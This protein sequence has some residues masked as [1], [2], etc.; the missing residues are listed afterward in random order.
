MNEIELHFSE[1]DFKMFRKFCQENGIIKTKHL[2]KTVMKKVSSYRGIGEQK[3][4]RIEVR[5]QLLR[6][7]NILSHDWIDEFLNLKSPLATNCT[8]LSGE[9]RSIITEFYSV[10]H[11]ISSKLGSSTSFKGESYLKYMNDKKFSI[12]IGTLPKE[13]LNLRISTLLSQKHNSTFQKSFGNIKV[14]DLFTHH[15]S[16]DFKNLN[17]SL[18]IIEDIEKIL[19]SILSLEE[20]AGTIFKGL[21]ENQVLFLELRFLKKYTLEKCGK[22]FGFSRERARQIETSILKKIF[23]KNE[24]KE[25]VFGLRARN[26][27]LKSISKERAQL[28]LKNNLLVEILKSCEKYRIVYNEKLDSF[29]FEDFQKVIEIER[30]LSSLPDIFKVENYLWEISDLFASIDIRDWDDT[31]FEK[32]LSHFNYVRYGEFFSKKKKIDSLFIETYFEQVASQPFRVDKKTFVNFQYEIEKYFG[33]VLNGNLKSLYGCLDRCPEIIKTA[34]LTYFHIGKLN[35]DYNILNNAKNKLKALNRSYIPLDEAFSTNKGELIK[36]KIETPY[37]FYYLLKYE[38]KNELKLG[39]G[40]S[41]NLYFDHDIASKTREDIVYEAL[42][43]LGKPIEKI[44]LCNRLG[45]KEYSLNDIVFRSEKF[46]FFDKSIIGLVEWVDIFPEEDQKILQHAQNILKIQKHILV[47]ELLADIEKDPDLKNFRERIPYLN[48][49]FISWYLKRSSLQLLG[50]FNILYLENSSIKNTSDLIISRIGNRIVDRSRIQRLCN[51]YNFKDATKSNMCSKLFDENKI[52]EID[53]D[54]IILT[55]NL[56]LHKNFIKKAED[57]ILKKMEEQNFISLNLFTN[58]DLEKLFKDIKLPENYS[59][60]I[61][62][63]KSILKLGNKLRL[64]L[65]QNADYRYDNI[66]FIKNNSNF[67]NLEELISTIIKER[68]TTPVEE[69]NICLYLEEIGLLPKKQLKAIRKLPFSVSCH[70]QK[71]GDNY[72]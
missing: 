1:N 18:T 69:K 2:T 62:L 12:D 67:S 13:V 14:G 55:K 31:F 63:L 8:Y 24:L 36:G 65:K 60:N 46:L 9:E 27:F 61:Y 19:F 50:N 37:T 29:I 5:L 25:L 39:S 30:Y 41:M 47:S 26:G 72:I 66:I 35:Y 6:R 49:Y 34:P 70:L 58:E 3:L 10:F 68:F 16:K 17:L 32:C 57:I 4:K 52:S 56:T 28:L 7:Q 42:Q 71:K 51:S 38:F 54:R 40:N 64:L 11:K 15:H 20:I 44:E 21:S 53:F 59:W 43:S 48:R 22:I 23:E 33:V 45:M